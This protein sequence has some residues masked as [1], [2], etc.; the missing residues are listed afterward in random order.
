[1]SMV[2]T[3]I[4]GKFS[5]YKHSPSDTKVK[6]VQPRLKTPD[7]KLRDRWIRRVLYSPWLTYHI[8][9]WGFI[10]RICKAFLWTMENR[11]NYRPHRCLWFISQYSITGVGDSGYTT[12][13]V[14]QIGMHK[15]CSNSTGA[16]YWR[17]LLCGGQQR[18]VCRL[19]SQN[20]SAKTTQ[21]PESAKIDTEI[22]PKFEQTSEACNSI[23]SVLLTLHSK[24]VLGVGIYRGFYFESWDFQLKV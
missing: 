11:R 6:L 14:V 23:C 3:T 5:C 4:A 8:I 15:P 21:V 1:M 13:T 2:F 10:G 22:L 12:T 19:C 16:D 24:D 17:S 18:P 7:E 9:T 20:A